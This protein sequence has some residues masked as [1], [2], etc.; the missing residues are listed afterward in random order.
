MAKVP[1]L[2]RKGLQKR[3]EGQR[4]LVLLQ[5][6]V[7][8]TQKI[9]SKKKVVTNCFPVVVE[10]QGHSMGH[11][12]K[13]EFSSQLFLNVLTVLRLVKK[14]KGQVCL[15]LKLKLVVVSR[16]LFLPVNNFLPKELL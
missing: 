11:H 3:K 14:R 2:Y 5:R 9:R 6:K 12:K 7:I 16:Q 8:L 13:E 4:A 15:F 10:L 1:L